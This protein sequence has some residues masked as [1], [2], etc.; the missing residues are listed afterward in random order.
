MCVVVALDGEYLTEF[1]YSSRRSRSTKTSTSTRKL[2][3]SS[4]RISA[5]AK[6]R[7]A[8]SRRRSRP[9]AR[10][11]LARANSQEQGAPP[12]NS[13]T[14]S[15]DDTDAHIRL[16]TYSSISTLFTSLP[17]L[18]CAGCYFGNTFRLPSIQMLFR[19]L[20]SKHVL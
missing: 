18:H 3:N 7:K 8:D 19:A 4:P 17:I 12:S 1:V 16:H 11:L 13:N 14:K 6:R 9:T 15:T 10:S 2:S 20:A 5:A